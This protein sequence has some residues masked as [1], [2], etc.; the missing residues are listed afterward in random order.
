VAHDLRTGQPGPSPIDKL[1]YGVPTGDCVLK[2]QEKII[3]KGE[4][5]AVARVCLEQKEGGYPAP[6]G[7]IWRIF[8]DFAHF[9]VRDHVEFDV[10]AGTYSLRA[11]TAGVSDGPPRLRREPDAVPSRPSSW[12]AADPNGKGWYSGDNHIHANYG[13]GEYHNSPAT[14]AD[15][16]AGEALN[17]GNFMVATPTATS[18][19]DRTYFRGRPDPLSTSATSSTGTRRCAAPSWGHLT[20]VNLKQVVEPVLHRLQG[21]RPTRTTSRRWRDLRVHARQGGLVNYTHPASR[22]DDIYRGA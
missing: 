19:Y 6:P 15:M 2:I 11:C 7:A 16:I 18:S 21:T 12:Q 8:R 1:D 22:I 9:Y 5:P 17:V 4:A 20:L 14:M 10:P 3:G 13:Y